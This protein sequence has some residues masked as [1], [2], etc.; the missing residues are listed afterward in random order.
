MLGL[1][2]LTRALHD[3]KGADYAEVRYHRRVQTRVRVASGEV[4]EARVARYEGVGVR[5]LHQGAWGFTSTTDLTP[6]GVAEA[7]KE[8][9][10]MARATAE[11]GGSRVR[12]LAPGKMAVGRFKPR[13]TDAAD[14]HSLEEKVRL[15]L[16]AEAEARR[17]PSIKAGLALYN[18][19]LDWKMITNTDGA[20]AELHDPKLELVVTAVAAENGDRVTASDSVGV[21]G[22]WGE[23]LARREPQA[24]AVKA[25][26]IAGRLL[27]AKQPK[28]ERATVILDPGM[29]GLLA[30]EAV[31]HT[32]EADFVLAG[33]VAKGKVGE[34]VASPLV[35]LVDSGPSLHMPGAGGTTLVD[36]EGVL[37][38]RT[39]LI[40]RG[41]LAGY[42]HSRETA[43]LFGVEATGSARAYEYS[44]EPI[45]RMR[46]TFIE[47]GDW[48]VEEMIRDVR[49]GYL[50]KGARNGQA[51][52]NGEFMF[53]AQEAY[54]IERGEVQELLRGVSISGVAFEVLKT[55]DAVGRDFSYEIGSG[56]CGKWQA[57]KVDG[58]GPHLRCQAI[59]GGV[60]GEG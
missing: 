21:T 28:G 22:G 3:L 11:T 43:A 9:L 45:I 58:G 56:Y 37:G 46:N 15:V 26:D 14:Q 53:A 5:V 48:G 34:E 47:P 55:V 33:S 23:L 41:V 1:E 42:L 36:D 8:A 59:V 16:E 2:D 30:H 57:I 29:V 24:M 12:E 6:R 39:V 52:A 50:L 38:Q 13:V 60:Q 44:D 17:H 7:L 31:G 27:H 25:A 18:E 19:L 20:A 4:E 10:S 32:V 54:R 49:H 40:D 35:T 51:D